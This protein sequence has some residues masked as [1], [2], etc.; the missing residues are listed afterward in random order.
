MPGYRFRVPAPNRLPPG[1]ALHVVAARLVKA[2]LTSTLLGRTLDHRGCAANRTQ[3]GQNCTIG[4]AQLGKRIA[5]ALLLLP[6]AEVVA[7]LLVAWAIGFF[8]ALALMILTSFAGGAVLRHAGRGTIAHI[9]V[10][11]GRSGAP[12]VATEP[13]G[14]MLAIGGILLLLPGF[15]T[16]LV[17]VGLLIRP[18]RRT[19][20]AAIGRALRVPGA[21]DGPAVVD[22]APDEWRSIPDPQL[23]RP[24][25]R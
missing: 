18:I 5:I 25:R 22:L 20:G 10:A 11:M 7:F 16:D 23:P 1:G 19:L 3:S 21:A 15:I 24:E 6:A 14:L 9:R 17:G 8:P 4:T 13:G 2:R 12:E